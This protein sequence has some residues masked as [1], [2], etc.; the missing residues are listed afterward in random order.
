MSSKLVRKGL[1]LV[2]SEGGLRS[3]KR[4][5]T[6]KTKQPSKKRKRT[7]KAN[8]QKPRGEQGLRLSSGIHNTALIQLNG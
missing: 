1:D 4:K 7:S 8:K 6:Q 5:S 3:Q 2:N